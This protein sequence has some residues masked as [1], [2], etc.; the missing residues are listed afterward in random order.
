MAEPVGGRDPALEREACLGSRRRHDEKMSKRT[1]Y[2]NSP[3]RHLHVTCLYSPLPIPFPTQASTRL[4]TLHLS[5][6]PT[7][8]GRES[9]PEGRVC[10]NLAG[11]RGL[12]RAG[13]GASGG[14]AAVAMGTR[15]PLRLRSFSR[16][17]SPPPSARL[18]AR[19]PGRLGLS[20]R[21]GRGSGAGGRERA[22]A[23]S[24][25]RLVP[26]VLS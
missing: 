11:P 4:P 23:A 8:R 16:S 21:G 10:A 12:G 14:D 7:P 22:D 9:T 18:P 26:R 17:C 5:S 19:R 6:G 1:R 15:R 3:K 25:W 2:T 13:G 20:L 24:E